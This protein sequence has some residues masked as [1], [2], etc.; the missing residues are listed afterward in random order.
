MI[1]DLSALSLAR[2]RSL[3]AAR[4]S[5][6]VAMLTRL[7]VPPPS[8]PSREQLKRGNGH[9]SGTVL[10]RQCASHL[11]C[12]RAHDGQAR[13]T[14][15][16]TMYWQGVHDLRRSRVLGD[17]L[18][19]GGRDNGIGQ[20]PAGAQRVV[21]D[22]ERAARPVHHAAQH[23]CRRPRQHIYLANCWALLV[24]LLE[25]PVPEKRRS[26][27]AYARI[28]EEDCLAYFYQAL[29]TAP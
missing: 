12:R 20:R 16:R 22:A 11:D 10:A 29:A 17:L 26:S 2:Y 28:G 5:S 15:L 21:V 13:C 1:R 9:D 19:Q 14:S 18:E 27:T 6:L 24:A 23:R 25:D 4:S 3:T 7:I 8:S